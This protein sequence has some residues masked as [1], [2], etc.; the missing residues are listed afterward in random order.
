MSIQK[1]LFLSLG[2]LVAIILL[3]GAGCENFLKPDKGNN[4]I[5]CISEGVPVGDKMCCEGLEPVAVD[6]AMT[7]CMPKGT[8]GYDSKACVKEGG[9]RLIDNKCCPGL[10]EKDGGE[11]PTTCVKSEKDIPTNTKGSYQSYST[12]KLGLAEKGKVVLFFHAP[13]CPNCRAFE[14][15]ILE[16]DLP[17]GLHILK[18]DYDSANDLKKKYGVT[19]QH[20]LV[21]IDRDGKM[22]KKWSA[23]LG[24][25]NDIV[26]KIQ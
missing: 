24:G 11:G 6:H 25:V 21:W 19:T 16:S 12:E 10:V 23:S 7:M 18:V 13:W 3:G 9:V 2:G 22:L 5:S 1:N 17:K 26:Q 14:K 8:R 4:T 15:D 20:T